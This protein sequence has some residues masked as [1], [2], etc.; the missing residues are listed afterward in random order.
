V[1]EAGI[2]DVTY[3]ILALGMA[4]GRWKIWAVSFVVWMMISVVSYSRGYPQK[5]YSDDRVAVRRQ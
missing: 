5:P 3:K 1:I 4:A 2:K